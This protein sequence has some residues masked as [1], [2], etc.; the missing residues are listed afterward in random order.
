MNKGNKNNKKFT[1]LKYI[2]VAAALLFLLLP[3]A[4]TN[5]MQITTRALVTV[6]G[7][8][9]TVDGGYEVTAQLV[10]P[11]SSSDTPQTQDFVYAS[12]GTLKSA[13]DGV[14]AKT[15]KRANLAHC[16]LLFLGDSALKESAID[17][18]EFFLRAP[19]VDNGLMLAAASGTAK[20]AVKKLSGFDKLSAFSLPDFLS[21]NN[22]NGGNSTVTLKNFMEARYSGI[23]DLTLPVIDITEKSGGEKDEGGEDDGNPEFPSAELSAEFKTAVI[24]GGKLIET[25]KTEN[26]RRLAWL[27]KKAK[28]GTLVLENFGGGGNE[29]IALDIKKKTI[30]KKAS[31]GGGKPV[32]T[33]DICLKLSLDE[34]GSNYTNI[35]YG[36]KKKLSGEIKAAAR[37][38]I[39][40]D[41]QSLHEECV[42]GG[43]DIMSINEKF[44][45]RKNKRYKKYIATGGDILKDC[46][47]KVKTDCEIKI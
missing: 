28:T 32:Y 36:E 3:D 1:R 37:E 44:F 29:K 21:Q 18:L 23:G 10:L 35:S 27:D 12:G 8:D 14:S 34:A 9:R 7:V 4:I 31:F 39:N 13:L 33:V 26:T 46:L 17:S 5:S 22:A 20:D 24:K 42:A 6:L 11:Q 43:F 30:K 16:K 45:R 40:A 15:G 19:E 47:I 38:K 25:L 41:I 2:A